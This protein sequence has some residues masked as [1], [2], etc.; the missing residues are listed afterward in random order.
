MNK[1]KSALT[2]NK[3]TDASNLEATEIYRYPF[4]LRFRV[5]LV[6]ELEAGCRILTLGVGKRKVSIL[7]GRIA[8]WPI[9]NS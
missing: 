6:A 4:A 5:Q 7:C 8:R 9:Y 3:A 1:T 2:G